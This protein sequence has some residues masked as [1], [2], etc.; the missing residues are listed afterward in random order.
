MEKIKSLA[1]IAHAKATMAKLELRDK[2]EEKLSGES[3]LIG[4]VAFI[5][6]VIVII[7]GVRAAMINIFFGGDNGATNDGSFMGKIKTEVLGLFDSNK[8]GSTTK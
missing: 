5:L 3:D 1:C 7:L 8:S 4:K 2:I 6:I